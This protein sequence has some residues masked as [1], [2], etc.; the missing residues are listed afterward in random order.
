MQFGGVRSTSQVANNFMGTGRVVD[1]DDSDA[2][3]GAPVNVEVEVSAAATVEELEAAATP[4]VSTEEAE[5]TSAGPTTPP[6]E[7][8][9]PGPCSGL[10]EISPMP[11]DPERVED[12]DAS[13]DAMPVPG[14]V[15]SPAPPTMEGAAEDAMPKL[16]PGVA[17][18]E[19]A[20]APL[21]SAA[22]EGGGGRNPLTME[23]MFRVAPVVLSGRRAFLLELSWS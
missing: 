8:E 6:P 22:P 23:V 5:V 20:A 14:A 1:E 3:G 16:Y 9:E 10:P 4:G 21:V 11:A 15:S 2:A 13:P 18:E 17:A 7:E 12:T 19:S